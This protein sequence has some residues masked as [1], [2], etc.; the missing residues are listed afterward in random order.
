MEIL[1]EENSKYQEL[2]EVEAQV[3]RIVPTHLVFHDEIVFSQKY[4]NQ[5]RNYLKKLI[6]SKKLSIDIIFNFKL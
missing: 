5:T 3:L 6:P 1:L 4:F 2:I